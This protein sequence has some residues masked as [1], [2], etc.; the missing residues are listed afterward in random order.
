MC[1]LYKYRTYLFFLLLIIFKLNFAQQP[2]LNDNYQDSLRIMFYNVENL[3]DPFDDSLKIDEEFTF[4]GARHWTWGKFQTKLT[5][6]YKTILAA[7]NPIPPA[8]IGLCEIENRFV[9]NQLVYKTPFA[10]LDY[11]IVHE[12]SPDKRGIDVALLF[13]PN[14]AELI[15]HEAVNVYFP[16]SPDSK[17]R[18]V[19]YS[20][21]LVFGKDT[22]HVF[23]N[24]WPSRW[25][26]QM[27]TD[28]KRKRVADIVKNKTDSILI[29]NAH[30]NIIIM[31]DFNDEPHDESL[32]L[33][34]NAKNVE[35]NTKLINLM[36]PLSASASVG[37]HKYQDQWG[38]LDQIIISKSLILPTNQIIVKDS[39]AK[40]FDASFLM[41][42]DIKFMGKKPFRTFIGFKYHGGYS[43]HLPVFIDLY[44]SL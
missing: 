7:G 29:H 17:T 39:T 15:Y 9:L 38:I 4:E 37:S 25:G 12:E 44:K 16:F 33:N 22:L 32:Y 41:E 18:D 3:F 36:L 30:A 21:L 24:H 23:V 31:G 14:R 10:K 43:D 11:R 40:I 28:P 26:G 42:D 19:L 5:H 35:D 20:K 8:I 13:D 2:K 27:A 6:I 1:H 34:L